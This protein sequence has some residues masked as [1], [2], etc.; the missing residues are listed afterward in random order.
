MFLSDTDILKRVKRRDIVI[1]PFLRKQLEPASYDLRLHQNFRI[2]KKSSVTHID[3]K[4]KFEVT[5]LVKVGK[6]EAFV[7]HPGEFVL[8][9]TYEKIGLPND[10]MGMLEGRSSLGRLGLIVHATAS[11]IPAGF[12]GHLTFEISNISNLPIKL[13]AG[14][15]VAQLSFA[16]LSS[17]VSVPYG[18]KGS[19]YQNQEP[20]TGSRIWKDFEK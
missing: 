3:V 7:I 20:P 2:F 8:A 5:E 19:K 12:F 15:R 9:S 14:M 13:Y 16:V 4:Q 18:K 17:P 10:L 11:H 6:E 1:K